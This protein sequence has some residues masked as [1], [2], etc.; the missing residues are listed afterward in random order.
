MSLK[1]LTRKKI[2]E[3]MI[4]LGQPTV[5]KKPSVWRILI[6]DA[7]TTRILSSCARM[8]ELLPYGITNAE[9]IET[10][11]QPFPN[12]EAIYFISPT[13]KS[14]EL[15]VN[16]FKNTPKYH[17]V[18]LFFTTGIPDDLFH[19]LTDKNLSKRIK[20]LK[21]LYLD[22]NTAESQVFHFDS[23]ESFTKLFDT[24]LNDPS[25][26]RTEN[27]RIANRLVTVCIT[28][29][30][31][32][33]I[34]YAPKMRTLAELFYDKLH[35]VA[36]KIPNFP[37]QTGRPQGTFLILDRTVDTIAPILHEFTYQAMTYDLLDIKG[38]VYQFEITQG[39]GDKQK[40]EVLL[41]ENDSIWN[42]YRHQHIADTITSILESFNEFV[43]LNLGDRLT[44]QGADSLKQMTEFIKQMPEQQEMASKFSLHI[45]LAHECM[46][47]FKANK[48]EAIGM[49]EQDMATGEDPEGKPAKNPVSR[50]PS[51]LHDPEISVTDKIRLIMIYIVTQEGIREQDSRALMEKAGLS[52]P[53]QFLIKN[54]SCLG[55]A[56]SKRDGRQNKK[57]GNQ[58]KK[59][60]DDIPYELSR[61][62]PK[63]K[64]LLQD[65][66]EGQ[67]GVEQL[68]FA[69]AGP[70]SSKTTTTATTSLKSK[71]GFGKEKRKQ[72]EENLSTAPRMIVFIAGGVTYSECRS[73]YELSKSHHVP[74]TIGST[75][76]LTPKRFIEELK[77]LRQ[78][79]LGEN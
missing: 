50:L 54:L 23:P 4:Q 14:I 16:D 1:D 52:R 12:L 71:G 45:T 35:F 36:S 66:I 24:E 9:P 26:L 41:S 74:V 48:L 75:H 55:V 73:A 68:P 22:F 64:E 61:Y 33:V 62:V 3:E 58:R 69:G 67:V 28:L 20:H 37:P 43:K 65:L 19:L 39:S 46:K 53:E 32:P 18:H 49:L 47:A 44:K 59:R 77:T 57:G 78:K 5:G 7:H 38:D 6:L 60:T 51:F 56:V 34:R 27:D 15:L 21:E 79:S 29:G 72:E 30:E 40:K 10:P 76:L 8:S 42:A 13:Q 63:V 11:R 2:F 25:E 70:S 17:A 31:L